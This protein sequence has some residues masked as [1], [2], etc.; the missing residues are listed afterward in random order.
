MESLQQSN[1]LNMSTINQSFL[2]DSL[3][4]RDIEK[5]YK[6]NKNTKRINI[7]FE[8]ESLIMYFP[9]FENP[10]LKD[11]NEENLK[12]YNQLLSSINKEIY[13]SVIQMNIIPTIKINKPIY[14]E[15]ITEALEAIP[16]L[17]SKELIEKLSDKTKFNIIPYLSL[18]NLE[19]FGEEVIKSINSTKLDK[20]IC[21]LNKFYLKK[22]EQESKSSLFS[23]ISDFIS[24]D[25]NMESSILYNIVSNYIKLEKT[26]PKS[27]ILLQL[28]ESISIIFRKTTNFLELKLLQNAFKSIIIK[29]IKQTNLE[30]NN[31]AKIID[32]SSIIKSNDNDTFENKP[33]T[34]ES[35]DNYF[36]EIKNF[37]INTI[38][39]ILN[40]ENFN[41]LEKIQISLNFAHKL[42]KEKIF[43]YLTEKNMIR[44]CLENEIN[45]NDDHENMIES[46]KSNEENK[47]ID[48]ITNIKESIS[49][50]DLMYKTIIEKLSTMSEKEI[51]VFAPSEKE[52]VAV[53]FLLNP[54]EVSFD[55][56]IELLFQQQ[57]EQTIKNNNSTISSLKQQ[58][59]DYKNEAN[60]LKIQNDQKEKNLNYLRNEI[61][62]KTEVIC[63]LEK[64]VN[65]LSSIIREKQF[66]SDINVKEKNVVF[67]NQIKTM[68]EFV[69]LFKTLDL[70]SLN[71]IGCLND[72]LSKTSKDIN[73][74][75]TQLNQNNLITM[76]K[77]EISSAN[78]E[79]DIETIKLE[80]NSLKT[81]VDKIN[82]DI[83][84]PIIDSKINASNIKVTK[85]I[86][87]VKN[88]INTEIK[89][90][91]AN[92]TNAIKKIEDDSNKNQSDVSALKAIVETQ[93]TKQDQHKTL[94]DNNINAVKAVETK[95]TGVEAKLTNEVKKI[96]DAK[97]RTDKSILDL[98]NNL[99]E[100]KAKIVKVQGDLTTNVTQ[101]NNTITAVKNEIKK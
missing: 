1:T 35:S 46:Q 34:L 85:K 15:E 74:I 44:I 13:N 17:P 30:L 38:I 65:L 9:I 25:D 100:E 49:I 62:E 70:G 101:I 12:Y 16:F 77:N 29:F 2:F 69:S 20:I 78:I 66:M 82:K 95:I 67:N 63:N 41:I 45:N 91:E 10:D 97:M 4:D 55:F 73:D 42:P 48:K 21:S 83:T 59:E 3:I 7:D 24:D 89:K 87:T 27:L 56:I 58:V 51:E 94:L 60:E 68:E 57:K 81:S 79:K 8:N 76:V 19:N 80:T 52:K 6:K 5:K 36:L 86:D 72:S 84:I 99:I 39:N 98:T 28:K 22:S 31:N 54:K 32:S 71:K 23:I 37:I 88:E 47:T 53:K 64:E 18:L 61:K 96:T 90:Q 93:K 14:D 75:K 43:L 33:N 40:L 50:S 26:S 11:K 92:N